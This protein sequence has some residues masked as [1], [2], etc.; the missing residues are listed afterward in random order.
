MLRLGVLFVA[1]AMSQG[2]WAEGVVGTWTLTI[3]TP[4]GVQ[5]PTMQVNEDLTG[6]YNSLRG[7]IPIAKVTVE[8]NSFSFPLK[9]TVPIGEITVDYAGQVDGDKLTGVVKNPRGEVPFSGVRDQ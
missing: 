5:H 3:D 6:T 7:P 8:G 1:C 2:V 9:I 4:R